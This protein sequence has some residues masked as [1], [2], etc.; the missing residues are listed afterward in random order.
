MEER[1]VVDEE[2]DEDGVPLAVFVVEAS[3]RCHV[4][5]LSVYYGHVCI[6]VDL[7]ACVC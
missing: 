5:T 1:E 2:K 3:F 6:D 7:S 4:I